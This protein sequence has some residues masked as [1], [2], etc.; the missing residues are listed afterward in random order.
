MRKCSTFKGESYLVIKKSFPEFE[1]DENLDLGAQY[2][3]RNDDEIRRNVRKAVMHNI[4]KLERLIERYKQGDGKSREKAAK[5]IRE[6]IN[7]N[8]DGYFEKIDIDG[9]KEH[10]S[11]SVSEG[12]MYKMVAKS[13]SEFDFDI[14]FD[15]GANYTGWKNK[16]KAISNIRKAVMH[17]IPKLEKLI[18]GYKK[19]KVECRE[20]AARLIKA[21]ITKH[22]ELSKY[23]KEIK[24]DTAGGYDSCP[25]FE[26][27]VYNAISM[28]FSEFGF[29][30]EDLAIEG[31]AKYYDFGYGSIKFD[32]KGERVI[33]ILLDKYGIVKEF[34]EDKNLH[35]LTNEKSQHSID[36]FVGNTFI[37]YHPLNPSNGKAKN[38]FRLDFN[39]YM[40]GFDS[41]KSF[42]KLLSVENLV[43]K[44]ESFNK[45]NHIT[46]PKYQDTWFW[47]IDDVEQLYD[48]L[49]DSAVKPLMN[50]RYR[51][52][53]YEQ[54][55]KDVDQAYQRAA[56]YDAKIVAMPKP[57][58]NKA[59]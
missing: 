37:E 33:G 41:S 2:R 50:K 47:H 45:W 1:F 51:N 57:R 7:G 18:E 24:I 48:V 23:S 17:D 22:G 13:F 59:A 11:E 39:S 8:I 26:G 32:S 30:E 9:V 46:R 54:F 28:S 56:D 4:P 6:K 16:K 27:S 20:K 35:V 52:I 15:L 53:T 14:N 29:Q 43:L 40:L 58:K 44:G 36:F 34:E 21:R 5:L 42:P 31:A 38:K 55:E 49:M 10:I 12:K 3:W 25:V 19:G